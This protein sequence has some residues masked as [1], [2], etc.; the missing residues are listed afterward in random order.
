MAS[1]TKIMT[2]LLALEKGN[3][4]IKLIIKERQLAVEGSSIYLREGEIITLEDLLYGLMLRSG[5]DSAIASCR[6]YWK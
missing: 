6:T 4:R 1:T 5:N 2:A 3:L